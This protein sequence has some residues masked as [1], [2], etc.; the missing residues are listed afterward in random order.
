MPKTRAILLNSDFDLDILVRNDSEGKI[1]S[2]LRIGDSVYQQQTLLLV[3]N[4]GEIKHSPLVGV[5]LNSFLLDDGSNDE[6]YQEIGSQ[7]RRDGMT[8]RSISFTDGKLN[9]ESEY[10]NN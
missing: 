6:L 10:E 2:G 9:V 4:K 3:A 1:V 5:G 8:V 7:F